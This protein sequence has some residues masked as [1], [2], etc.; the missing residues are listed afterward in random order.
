MLPIIRREKIIKFLE[1]EGSQSIIKIQSL[2]GV[3][4]ATV[5]RD[6]KELEKDGLVERV[7]GGARLRTPSS[8]ES[9]FNLR[10]KQNLNRKKGLLLRQ[11]NI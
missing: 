1:F 2:L 3:S 4:L 8:F 9:R 5:Y 10:I 6:L 11:S 7:N